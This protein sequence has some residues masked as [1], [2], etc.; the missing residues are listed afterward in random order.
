[1]SRVILWVLLSAAA[2][3]Q[4]PGE[5]YVVE[6]D[7]RTVSYVIEGGFAVTEGDIILG[8]AEEMENFRQAQARG[9]RGLRPR[10]VYSPGVGNVRLWTDATMYYTMEPDTPVQ[11]NLLA[12]IDYWNTIAPFRIL[13]RSSEPNYVTFRRIEID[14]ACNS[15]VG[16]VGG[17]QFIGVTSACSVGAAIHEIGHAFGLQH[18]QSRSDRDAFVTVLFDN[19][20]KRFASN[21]NVASNSINAGY[22]DYDSIM[23]YGVTGFGRNFGDTIAT[24]PP[25]IPIGQ[26]TGLSAGDIDAVSRAYGAIPT[27]TTIATTPAGLPVTVDG[28]TVT[29]PRAFDWAPGSQHTISVAEAQGT[30]PRYVFA[31]WSDGGAATHTI[32]AGPAVTVFCAQFQ[33]QY[34]VRAAVVSGEGSVS[35]IPSP[36]DGYLGDRQ[37]F[38]VTATPDAG[39]KFIRWSGTTGFNA[40]GAS[41]S[42]ASVRV[43]VAGAPPNYLASFT[44]APLHVVDSQPRGAQVIVDGTAYFTPVSFSWEPGSLHVLNSLSPQLQ[45]NSTRRFTFR[46]W[47]DGTAG[48]RQVTATAEGTTFTA[49]FLE[50]YL[51]SRSIVGGGTIQVSPPSSEGYYEAGSTVSLTALPGVG[52]TLR[53]WVGDLAGNSPTQDV[54]MDQQRSVLANFGS[55][56]PWLMYHAASFQLN[57]VPGTTAMIAAPGE[58]VSIFGENIG[59]ASAQSPPPGTD[60]RLPTAVGGVSV[61]FDNVASPITFAGPNQINVIV[62]YAVAGRTQTTIVVRGARG[63]LTNTVSVLPTFPGLFTY[64]GS[65]RGPVAALNQDGS[66]NSES[67]PA[68]PGSVV[69]LYGTGAGV[70]ERSFA[71]GQVI[72]SV[73]VAPRAPVYVRFDKLAGEVQFAGAAPFLV[74]GALQVNVVVPRDVV[75][76]GQVPVRLVVGSNSSPPGS[77]IWVR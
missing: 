17:Q 73:L 47:E 9:E 55:A 41:V 71:D 59:P 8:P 51:L 4:T 37:A 27:A 53:Y 3:G 7:G 15:S 28:E 13:P 77:T 69:V 49:N 57:H 42:A 67:N 54:T 64:D 48:V 6:I 32:T 56:F 21:F 26:R 19:I 44:S 50:E 39:S 30:S 61:T 46:D 11:G 70:L 72:G 76:G 24:V 45:G 10:S 14:A 20:D 74:N 63:N 23:H 22:Y 31:R 25:G 52:G 34:P 58:I 40:A 12:A 35:M 33:R 18:E 66:I 2:F 43:Q 1:M 60:G 68:A 36:E 62:P 5:V 75:G 16:M 38:R 65:G 29:T